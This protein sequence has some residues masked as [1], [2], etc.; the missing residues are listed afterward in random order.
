MAYTQPADV[1]VGEVIKASRA[2]TVNDA[3]ADLNSRLSL[4]EGTRGVVNG[5]YE[6]PIGGGAE[7]DN[8]TAT[9]QGSG[10]HSVDTAIFIDGEQSFKAVTNAAG[11]FV[12]LI[13]DT[14][15]LVSG[16]GDD[17]FIRGKVYATGAARIRGQI[18]FY[19]ESGTTP[20]LTDTF[21]DTDVTSLPSLDAWHRFR[22]WSRAPSGAR[23]WKPNF[24]LGDGVTAADI[25][26]D[27]IDAQ[28]NTP[29]D[30]VQVDQTALGSDNT[31]GTK[32]Y[33]VP[34]LGRAYTAR[35][36]GSDETATSSTY[37]YQG[38]IADT[39]AFSATGGVFPNLLNI[40]DNNPKEA[41]VACNTLGQVRVVQNVPVANP[42]D[43]TFTAW[44]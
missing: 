24:I 2:N 42:I 33:K 40:A 37:F 38:Y 19:D 23:Y 10:S 35:V 17:V 32:S 3:L 44:Q 12:S 22:G 1:S 27:G 5:S 36:Q 31:S 9:N 28:V 43:I 14:L 15:S 6:F 20:V 13:N 25:Y 7:A 4:Q 41:E 34:I 18:I 8:W 29:Y 21:F 39:A 16:A 26:L 30:W 11:G